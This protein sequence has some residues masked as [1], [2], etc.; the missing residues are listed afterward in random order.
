MVL[1]KSFPKALSIPGW[2]TIEE[3][4][5]TLHLNGTWELVFLST[6]KSMVGCC[7][8]YTIKYLP[9]GSIE[10]LKACLVAKGYTPT[11]G[12]D[13]YETFSHVAKIASVQILISLAANLGWPLFLLDVKNAFLLGDL[14]EEVYMEQT[15]QVF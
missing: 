12:V 1:P 10:R 11:Y 8:V 5:E 13:Y 2:R 9:D 7:W 15:T 3:E 6:G 4:M 14:Y